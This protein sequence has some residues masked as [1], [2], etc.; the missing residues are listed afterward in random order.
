MKLSASLR[1][2]STL[3]AISR[4]RASAERCWRTCIRS[5]EASARSSCADPPGGWT[6]KTKAT[7]LARSR[8]AALSQ[9][10]ETRSFGGQIALKFLRILHRDAVAEQFFVLPR[11]DG[12][13]DRRRTELRRGG[14]PPHQFDDRRGVFR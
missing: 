1:P 13:V 14:E 12:A 8:P 11:R 2:V 4:V 5:S 6:T 7:M 9:R 10:A 3:P